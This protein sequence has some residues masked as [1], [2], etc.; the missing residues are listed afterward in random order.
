MSYNISCLTQ[1]EV[2][3]IRAEFIRREKSLFSFFALIMLSGSFVIF[4]PKIADLISKYKYLCCK[5]R[6]KCSKDDEDNKVQTV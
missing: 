3:I 2:D 4:M 5:S 6:C 1:G